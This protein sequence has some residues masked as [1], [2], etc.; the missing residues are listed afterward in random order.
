MLVKYD[1]HAIG[2]D[3]ATTVDSF[4]K[5]ADSWQR[6]DTVYGWLEERSRRFLDTIQWL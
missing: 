5:Q 2:W 3:L 4:K 6:R 1:N